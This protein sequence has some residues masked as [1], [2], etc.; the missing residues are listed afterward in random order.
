MVGSTS[1]ESQ[2]SQKFATEKTSLG[3]D[4][5]VVQ[6]DKSDGVAWRDEM[7]QQHARELVIKEYFFGDARRALSPQIQQV[8]FDSL[9][10]YRVSP[11]QSPPLSSP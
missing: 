2:L 5:A 6:I 4:I 7:F 1:L 10:I 9:L 3:E 11:C 8:D